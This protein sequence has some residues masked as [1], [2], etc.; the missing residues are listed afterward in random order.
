MF[1]ALALSGVF[2]ID[3][4]RTEDN[5][6]QARCS[7]QP[8]WVYRTPATIYSGNDYNISK[9]YQRFVK[10]QLENYVTETGTYKS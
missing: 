6:N 9:I 5:L 10:M 7:Q 2:I 3:K 4:Q 1:I 8:A